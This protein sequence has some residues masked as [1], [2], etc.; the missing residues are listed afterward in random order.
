MS[1]RSQQVYIVTSGSYSSYDICEVFTTRRLAREYLKRRQPH[2]PWSEFR[3]ETWPLNSAKV[4]PVIDWTVWVDKDGNEVDSQSWVH[5]ECPGKDSSRRITSPPMH[6]Q[7]ST[8][9]V[10]ASSARGHDVALKIA[11]DKLAQ[12][13]AKEAG[14]WR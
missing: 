4:D 9:A 2:N 10:E 6:A 13:K 7:R 1:D 5:W 3:I 11:R 8:A 12:I 14:V